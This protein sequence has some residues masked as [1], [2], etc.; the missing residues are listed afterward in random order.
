M[1]NKVNWYAMFQQ[2]QY[3]AEMEEDE[4]LREIV[5]GYLNVKLSDYDDD[6]FEQQMNQ[7]HLVIHNIDPDTPID[8]NAEHFK[9][10]QYLANLVM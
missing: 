2:L 6:F 7:V 5:E 1:D 4:A 9:E 8:V 3:M 10:A